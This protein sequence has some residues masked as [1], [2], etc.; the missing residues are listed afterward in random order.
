M[1]HRRSSALARQGVG[2]T[3]LTTETEFLTVTL[4]DREPAMIRT[5]EWPTIARA[6][7]DS[8]KGMDEAR[9]VQALFDG[10]CDRYSLRV[11]QHVSGQTLVY[12]AYV[13]APAY[14]GKD[15]KGG[16]LIQKRGPADTPAAIRRVGA[17]CRLPDW[18]IRE[19]IAHLPAE[20]LQ[21]DVPT[22][23]TAPHEKQA[24]SALRDFFL[25]R[26]RSAIFR[27]PEVER[28]VQDSVEQLLIGR[29]MQKGQDYDREVGRVKISV[30]EVVPDFIVPKLQLAMEIKLIK[31]L[32][33]VR[34][35]VDEINADIRAYS[36]AYRQ[37]MFL[38]YDLGYIR[39]EIEF[40]HGLE[41]GGNVDILVIKH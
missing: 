20:E 36:S 30:K 7:G 11:R 40:R 9:H 38:V 39:D 5:A 29:G 31:T 25:T 19:C 35:V 14:V 28:D 32:A 6:S 13:A 2:D 27:V 21:V 26:L 4:T 41:K 16:E 33:R 23:T 37:I 34:E 8:F 3:T 18:I 22:Q 17:N 24:Y 15:Y 10:R 1:A 12:G